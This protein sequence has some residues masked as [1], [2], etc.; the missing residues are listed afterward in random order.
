VWDDTGAGGGKA[1][2]MWIVNDM[3]MVIIVPGHD[4]PGPAECLEF[5]NKGLYAD[6]LKLSDI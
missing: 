2:S 4:P 6:H 3:N 5:S 1:G